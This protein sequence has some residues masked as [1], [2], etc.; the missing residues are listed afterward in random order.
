[1]HIR[2]ENIWKSFGTNSVLEGVYVDIKPAT[3]H[4]LM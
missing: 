4:A 3:V 2:M 1:M